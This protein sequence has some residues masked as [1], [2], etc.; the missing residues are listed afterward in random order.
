MSVPKKWFRCV[1]THKYYHCFVW[2][3]ANNIKVPILGGPCL[4]RTIDTETGLLT[5]YYPTNDVHLE[6]DPMFVPPITPGGYLNVTPIYVQ[7]IIIIDN[8]TYRV[9][10]SADRD[11]LH[12]ICRD[13]CYIKIVNPLTNKE[14]WQQAQVIKIESIH[15]RLTKLPGICTLID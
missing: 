10:Q 12:Y 15:Y 1:V 3:T 4:V 7:C 8:N 14:N 6:N 13:K 2:Q 9:W 11:H 5:E